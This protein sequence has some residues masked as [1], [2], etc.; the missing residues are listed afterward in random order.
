MESDTIGFNISQY[1]P[2]VTL[3][4]TL[5]AGVL[6]AYA[7]VYFQQ[8]ARLRRHVDL[9]IVYVGELAPQP[10]PIVITADEAGTLA[11]ATSTKFND[12]TALHMEATKAF[13]EAAKAGSDPS[14]LSTLPLRMELDLKSNERH[15]V[16][17]DFVQRILKAIKTDPPTDRGRPTDYAT[18]MRNLPLNA[19]REFRRALEELL[20]GPDAEVFRAAIETK[21][22]REFHEIRELEGDLE[23]GRLPADRVRP[24]L[25][26]LRATLA[27]MASEIDR[28]FHTS[29]ASKDRQV[30]VVQERV[31]N[32]MSHANNEKRLAI[33][34]VI[35][36]GG[37]AP[38]TISRFGVI[39]IIG[40]GDR[41]C[42]LPLEVVGSDG[43][44]LVMAGNVAEVAFATFERGAIVESWGD[45]VRHRNRG[46]KASCRVRLIPDG[47]TV[48]SGLFDLSVRPGDVFDCLLDPK[49]GFPVDARGVVD[50]RPIV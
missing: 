28:A 48:R 49:E 27:A 22:T 29:R 19:P 47:T 46:T 20:Q 25:E 24:K 13:L 45:L 38:I 41:D 8:R 44:V 34:M 9:D 30:A 43:N 32:S 10:E 16:S 18:R 1:W 11:A 37:Q 42:M 36:N 17:V 23:R 15:T 50:T 39:Q 4:T 2:W 35:S 6:G 12:L 14:D 7:A 21:A 3:F 26:H 40:D 5:L 31:D 33:K